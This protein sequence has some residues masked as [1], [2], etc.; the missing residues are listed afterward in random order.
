MIDGYQI[1]EWTLTRQ[2]LKQNNVY[3]HCNFGWGGNSTGWY[4]FETDGS[5][6]F[7]SDDVLQFN[8]DYTKMYMNI[9]CMIMTLS[10][11]LI[12]AKDNI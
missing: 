8:D 3:C 5:I 2:I 1:R 6:L 7:E 10:A 4:L 9:M 12:S 11:I